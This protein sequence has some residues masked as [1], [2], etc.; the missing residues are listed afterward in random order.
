MRSR[1]PIFLRQE[2]ASQRWFNS[3]QRKEV[4]T[5]ALALHKFALAIAAPANESCIAIKCQQAGKRLVVASKV[6][7]ALECRSCLRLQIPN[8]QQFMWRLNRRWTQ[9]QHI[10]EAKNGDVA[11]NA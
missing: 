7:V 5:H 10:H 9:Q 4:P 3:Q 1:G 11:A 6:R 8:L 2:S